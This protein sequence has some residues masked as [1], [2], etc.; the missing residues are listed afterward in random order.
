MWETM[1]TLFRVVLTF[2]MF[3]IVLRR[4]AGGPSGFVMMLPATFMAGEVIIIEGPTS[5]MT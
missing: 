1:E 5:M 2:G 4:V 3:V